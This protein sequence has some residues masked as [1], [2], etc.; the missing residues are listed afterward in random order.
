MFPAHQRPVFVSK[1]AVVAVISYEDFPVFKL[2]SPD[3]TGGSLEL[4]LFNVNSRRN[5]E[6]SGEGDGITPVGCHEVYAGSYNYAETVVSGDPEHDTK[7]A[8]PRG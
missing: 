2:I 5:S 3:G 1:L 7:S 8:S 4:C 6:A